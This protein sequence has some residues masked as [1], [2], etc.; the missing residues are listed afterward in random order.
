MPIS[1]FLYKNRIKTATKAHKD[2]G[3]VPWGYLIL[4]KLPHS[5]GAAVLSKFLGYQKGEG[6]VIFLEIFGHVAG[7]QFRAGKNQ[8]I[9]NLILVLCVFLYVIIST[10][11]AVVDGGI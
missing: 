8:I 10:S 2:D 3:S 5:S 11:S 1:L 7:R 4:D 6:E 9:K